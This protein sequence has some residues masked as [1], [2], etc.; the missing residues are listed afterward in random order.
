MFFLA[1]NGWEVLDHLLIVVRISTKNLQNGVGVAHR[2][3][4][5]V[6]SISLQIE[7]PTQNFCSFEKFRQIFKMAYSFVDVTWSAGA[8]KSNSDLKVQT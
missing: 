6:F 7:I 3:F 1:E 8:K 2:R 4:L 5:H